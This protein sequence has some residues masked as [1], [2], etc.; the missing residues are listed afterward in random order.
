MHFDENYT[1]KSFRTL[2]NFALVGLRNLKIRHRLILSYS[3]STV[4]PLLPS[5]FTPIFDTVLLPSPDRCW[6]CRFSWHVSL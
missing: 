1:E 2:Q 5:I 3:I 6:Y 4:L